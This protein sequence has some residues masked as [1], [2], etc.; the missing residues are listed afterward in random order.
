VLREPAEEAGRCSRRPRRPALDTK[1]EQATILQGPPRRPAAPPGLT[2]KEAEQQA[3]AE[4]LVLVRAE[5]ASGYRNV[6]VDSTGVAKRYRVDLHRAGKNV[7]LGCF[8]TAEEAALVFARTP[9]G[10]AAALTAPPLSADEALQQAKAE[11]LV[12]VRAHRADNKTGFKG[13]SF[14][15]ENP[16]RPYRVE[17]RRAGKTVFRGSYATAEEAA[18]WKARMDEGRVEGGATDEGSVSPLMALATLAGATAPV[19]AASTDALA[20]ATE[21]VILNALPVVPVDASAGLSVDE[22]DPVDQIAL[23]PKKRK[24]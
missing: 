13:V 1:E 18:L 2:A 5:N 17:V 8:G 3:K 23:P 22:R 4:G 9:E 19:A 6:Q 24:F 11:G 7:H 20:P 12:L 21:L 10:Q 14:R 16:G 15:R